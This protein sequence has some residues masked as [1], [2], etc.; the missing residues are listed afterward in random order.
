[1]R[2]WALAALLASIEASAW[3]QSGPVDIVGIATRYVAAQEGVMQ[4]GASQ[5]DVDALIGFYAPDYAYYHPQFGAKVTGLDTVRTGVTSHLGE[6]SDARIEI[7]GIQTNGDMVSLALRE[8]FVDVATGKRIE[9]ERTTVL[10]IRD[11]KVVQRVD[12]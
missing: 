9:R 8:T 10:T 7:R 11:G 4:K 3:A 1:M 2:F 12:I 5:R 6:T